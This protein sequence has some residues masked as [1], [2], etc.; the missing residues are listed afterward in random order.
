MKRIAAYILVLFALCL[1]AGCSKKPA[2]PE[3][4]NITARTENMPEQ[5]D[6]PME[7]MPDDDQGVIH[8]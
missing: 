6:E 5:G 3:N 1:M 2:V 7:E 4:V 8:F